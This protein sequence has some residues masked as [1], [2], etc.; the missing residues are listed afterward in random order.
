[1]GTPTRL[2]YVELKT[3]HADNGPA[4]IARVR[5]SKSGRTI[6][7]AGKALRRAV[8]GGVAGNFFDV[9]TGEEYWVSGVKRNGRDRHWAGSGKVD[10]EATAVAEYL[11]LI[12]A[13]ELDLRRLRVIPDLPA[14]DPQATHD[15]QSAPLEE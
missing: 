13:S 2:R 10:I 3:G 11:R 5:S 6:Y 9:K 4:V 1:M 14:T 12:G 7:V 8:R 15:D